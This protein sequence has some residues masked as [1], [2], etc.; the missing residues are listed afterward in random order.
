MQTRTLDGLLYLE[1]RLTQIGNGC[2]QSSVT[3]YQ[4]DTAGN[5]TRKQTSTQTRRYGYDTQ[6]RLIQVTDGSGHYGKNSSLSSMRREAN[7]IRRQQIRLRE[8]SLGV[9]WQMQNEKLML[10]AKIIQ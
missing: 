4:C 6:N 10:A 9:K 1:D 3:C 8:T 5:L 2:G 7:Q